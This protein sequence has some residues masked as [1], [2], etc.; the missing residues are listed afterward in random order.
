MTVYE[1]LNLT[2]G[3]TNFVIQGTTERGK[4]VQVAYGV[5][6]DIKFPLVPYGKY[7]VE[8][9]S[10]DENC[11]YIIIDSNINFALIN[12]IMTDIMH[13]DFVGYLEN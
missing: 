12:P 11:F 2:G 5:V 9:L 7:E 1:L 6:D 13:N 4:I 3:N 8:H 10:V